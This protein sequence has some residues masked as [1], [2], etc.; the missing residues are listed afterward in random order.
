[1]TGAVAGMSSSL[2]LMTLIPLSIP[3]PNASTRVARAIRSACSADISW[4]SAKATSASALDASA[5]GRSPLFY[6]PFDCHREYT[7][8]FNSSPSGSNRFGR[9]HFTHEGISRAKRDGQLVRVESGCCPLTSGQSHID[10]GHL[11]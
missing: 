4:F 8:A 5:P 10:Q 1:M 7:R 2:P 9:R 6:P 11:T 3:P